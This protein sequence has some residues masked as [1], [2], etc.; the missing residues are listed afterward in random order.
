ME[1]K[2]KIEAKQKRVLVFS[3][4]YKGYLD[5]MPEDLRLAREARKAK[6]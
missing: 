4:E 3:P 1:K 5:E 6:K 2:K